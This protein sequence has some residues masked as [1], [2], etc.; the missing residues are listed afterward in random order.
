M[1]FFLKTVQKCAGSRTQ[2]NCRT[3]T[4]KSWNKTCE[5]MT[6]LPQLCQLLFHNGFDPLVRIGVFGF[7]AYV[8]LIVLLRASGKRTLSKMNAYDLVVTVALGSTLATILLNASISLT[9]GILAF[10]V[11][12][13]LQY[14]AA[15][16]AVRS[17]RFDKLL[18]AEPS[19]LFYQGR[20][21]HQT[22]KMQRVTEGEI[23]AAMREQG[24]DAVDQV[25]AVV[26]E[27]S[28]NFTVIQRKGKTSTQKTYEQVPHPRLSCN[29]PAQR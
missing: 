4:V 3:C 29:T 6:N 5:S 2:T 8:T 1:G 19:M 20:F 25:E 14:A 23:L 7:L 9:E 21:L 15:W 22:M 18:K 10:L 13:G 12:I 26:L 27:A 11:L 24:I 28:G 16:L 17:K